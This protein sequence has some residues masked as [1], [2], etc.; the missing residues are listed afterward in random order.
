MR[1]NFGIR[2]PGDTALHPIRINSSTTPPRPLK[3]HTCILCVPFFLRSHLIFPS[4]FLSKFHSSAQFHWTIMSC[5]PPFTTLFLVS[6]TSIPHWS[7][8]VLSPSIPFFLT[9][10]FFAF[11]SSHFSSP[12]T[13]FS[14]SLFIPVLSSLL[15]YLLRFC[16]SLPLS[17]PFHSGHPIFISPHCKSVN[18]NSRSHQSEL[19]SRNITTTWHWR[20][21]IPHRQCPTELSLLSSSGHAIT[22][23]LYIIEQPPNSATVIANMPL[24]PYLN[25]TQPF[26]KRKYI[27]FC[28]FRFPCPIWPHTL[29]PILPTSLATVCSDLAL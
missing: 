4:V 24:R 29:P 9:T 14:S 26:P 17:A 23:A 13:P 21:V 18:T 28:W 20:S 19:E 22:P 25:F 6:P 15:I 1:R 12:S 27:I 11:S 5:I 8:F 2:L 16:A 10:M 3:M 7:F